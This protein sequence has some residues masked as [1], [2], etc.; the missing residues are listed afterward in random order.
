MKFDWTKTA[1]LNQFGGETIPLHIQKTGLPF[2][3]ALRLYGAIDLYIG[4]REDVEIHD[5]G[6]EWRVEGHRRP[7]R[8][9]GRCEKAFRLVWKNKK[10]APEVYC[11]DLENWLR[12]GSPPLDS[13]TVEGKGEWDAV[14]QDGIRGI[15]AQSYITLQ[16][17]QTSK[18]ECK[19]TIP[20]AD[21]MLAAAGRK[22]TD[23]FGSIT[24]LPVFEGRVDFS[25]VVSPL[26][27]RIGLPN[28]L[29]FQA[30]ALLA[31]RTSLFAEGYYKDA[32][33]RVLLKAVVFD[34]D[35]GGQRSDNYSGVVSISST[36][37]GKIDSDR[38]VEELHGRPAG[39]VNKAWRRY[40]RNYQTNDLTPH[41]LAMAYWMMQ[42][43][44]KHL[45]DDHFA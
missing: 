4:L 30:L 21:A 44:A 39:V 18:K 33:G 42:P 43:A 40:G 23:G 28:V 37:I 1:I 20:L 13:H 11:R 36:A 8:L 25:K 17:G 19:A 29:C 12:D 38:F 31:L 27:V 15:A 5:H 2:F 41:A 7:H 45:S 24:F 32:S 3:D 6:S 22:R 26:R 9:V 10:P 14:L 35:L 34:T 16:S